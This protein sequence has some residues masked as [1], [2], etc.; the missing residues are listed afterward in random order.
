MNRTYTASECVGGST[1]WHLVQPA[2]TSV[3]LSSTLQTKFSRTQTHTCMLSTRIQLFPL[4]CAQK[5]YIY[6]YSPWSIYLRS[7]SFILFLS[8]HAHTPSS[9]LLPYGDPFI[10]PCNIQIKQHVHVHVWA[11][12]W[13]V[14]QWEEGGKYRK[15]MYVNPAGVWAWW[16][17]ISHD[18]HWLEGIYWFCL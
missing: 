15:S 4:V 5:S 7:P 17:I 2:V 14:S 12:G 18:C 3:G 16:T 6:V 11:G 13:Y 1:A 9:L 8:T 10:F